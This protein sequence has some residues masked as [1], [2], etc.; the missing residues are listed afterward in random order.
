MTREK[1]YRHCLQELRGTIGR[2]EWFSMMLSMRFVFN[3]P[4]RNIIR[5]FNNQSNVSSLKSYK[6]ISIHE[7]FPMPIKSNN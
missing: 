5:N 2:I 4:I 6:I 1:K 7:Q 3:F